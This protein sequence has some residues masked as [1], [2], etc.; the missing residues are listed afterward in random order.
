MAV[1][2]FKDQTGARRLFPQLFSDIVGYT[3]WRGGGKLVGARHRLSLL[4][5]EVVRC[6]MVGSSGCFLLGAGAGDLT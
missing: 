6:L 3:P 5:S 2:L 1:I 4:V